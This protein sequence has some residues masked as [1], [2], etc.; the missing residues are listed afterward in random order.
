MSESEERRLQRRIA[1]ALASDCDANFEQ[2]VVTYQDRI[3]AFCTGLSKDRAAAQEIAQDTFVRAYRALKTYD[4]ARIRELS[5]R[6][7]LYQIAL[8]LTKN[9]SRRKRFELT[10]IENARDVRAGTD[11]AREAEQAELA[12]TIR[13]ALRRLPAHMRAAVVLR[14]LD[15]L[16]YEEIARITGYPEGTIKSHVHRGLALLRKELPHVN[17]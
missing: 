4:A 3:V 8:N 9:A 13:A 15:E 10:G 1:A 2:F 14:H 16:P 11:I 7:W 17:L 6:A 12:R 5:L